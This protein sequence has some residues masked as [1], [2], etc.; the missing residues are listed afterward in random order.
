MDLNFLR[1][2]R[3]R[4]L[5]EPLAQSPTMPQPGVMA[6]DPMQPPQAQNGLY[7]VAERMAQLYTPE[8]AANDRY[9]EMI[10]KYPNQP[11]VGTG[12]KIA[13]VGLAALA[14]FA[15]DSNKGKFVFDEITGKNKY[16]T[17][18]AAWKNQVD[19]LEKAADNERASNT[20]KQNM[21]HQQIAD[22]LRKQAQDE[23][24]KK[25]D[26]AAAVAKQ[27]AD[28]YEF[29]ARNPNLKF[30]FSGP[31]VMVTDP[32]TGK[33]SDTKIP[34]GS[35]SDADKAA[36]D[37]KN[38]LAKIEAQGKNQQTVAETR[39]WKIGTIPDPNDPSKQIGVRYNEITGETVPIKV[40]GQATTITPTGA[41]AKPNADLDAIQQKTRDTLSA[42]D[43]L[44]DDKTDTLKDN[45]KMAIGASRMLGTQFLPATNARA[46]D[47][48]IKRLKSMLI[49]DLVGQM[50]TQSR[51]GATGFGQL[52]VK[53]LGV[54]ENAA[55]KLD[56]SLD[57]KTFEDELKRIKQHLKK[58]LQP[59]DGLT[60]TNTIKKPTAQELIQKYGGGI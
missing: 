54:L 2:L 36:L 52:S 53:E 13:G 23:T 26:A 49:I 21:A 31:T 28:A 33:V 18:V 60:P 20:N 51:T 1:N 7:N 8:T 57:E 27:R 11:K 24:A 46:T 55:S 22:E 48:A 4:N 35:L 40:N 16:A 32:T 15:G 10:G 12:R 44:L 45:T 29:K 39:G 42:L 14:D 19:P 6:N 30:N 9:N 37:Q 5:F 47:A 25:N 58:I 41:G 38:D 43:E 17:D 50:K 59:K 3:L 34:T 56:P